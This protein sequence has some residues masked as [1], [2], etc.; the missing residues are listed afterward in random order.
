MKNYEYIFLENWMGFLKKDISKKRLID[1]TFY[2]S[3]DSNTN[4]MYSSK[5]W[6]NYGI[7]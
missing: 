7:C 6:N 3:H 2:G 4:T 1:L 5:I